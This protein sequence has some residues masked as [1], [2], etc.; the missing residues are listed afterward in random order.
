MQSSPLLTEF[1]THCSSC[2]LF[3][4]CPKLRVVGG[5][6]INALYKIYALFEPSPVRVVP[7]SSCALVFSINK[8][9]TVNNAQ[10]ELN[11]VQAMPNSKLCPV[12]QNDAT[13]CA[14]PCLQLCPIRVEALSAKRLVLS[15]VLSQLVPPSN[16]VCE[17]H[18]FRVRLLHQDFWWQSLGWQ[19]NNFW[20]RLGAPSDT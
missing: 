19:V 16:E 5:N 18:V 1:L 6:Q 12:M 17:E 7:S 13:V 3:D 14:M 20:I 9:V 8:P 10:I 11:P 4:L 2:A 15:L